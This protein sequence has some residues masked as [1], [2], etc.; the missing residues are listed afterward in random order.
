MSETWSTSLAVA[1]SAKWPA[2]FRN[3]SDESDSLGLRAV[4][5][6]AAQPGAR[7]GCKHNALGLSCVLQMPGNCAHDVMETAGGDGV[8]KTKMTNKTHRYRCGRPHPILRTDRVR[9]RHRSRAK[10]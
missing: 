8:R 5:S 4:R 2:T 9:Q 3:E 1:C 6:L 10:G 7:L